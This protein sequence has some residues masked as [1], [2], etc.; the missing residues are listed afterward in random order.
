MGGS[1]D[2]TNRYFG[3]S[4]S[5]EFN[6]KL[7]DML[8]LMNIYNTEDT[9]SIGI[10]SDT[11]TSS[12][13][14]FNPVKK[15]NRL[16]ELKRNDY[17]GDKKRCCLND[18]K[19]YW[20]DDKGN[21]TNPSLSSTLYTC[22]PR[23]HSVG[24]DAYCDD[25]MIEECIDKE[26][27]NKKCQVWIHNLI[28]RQNTFENVINKM[29][30]KCISNVNNMYCKDLLETIR[31]YNYQRFN[32]FADTIL[33]SQ[34]DKTDLKCAFP[35]KYIENEE[36]KTLS[37]KECWYKECVDSELWKL[38]TKNIYK[39]N[40]CQLYECNINIYDLNTVDQSEIKIICKNKD[41]IETQNTVKDVLKSESNYN[42]FLI[43]KFDIFVIFILL[44]IF[45]ITMHNI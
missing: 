2:I 20:L 23:S 33:E 5:Q 30:N 42:M 8:N 39:R 35:P 28:L 43:T 38:L 14:E 12:L 17:I 10:N 24:F 11:I 4:S 26:N 15:P 29:Y 3:H 18:E 21:D 6:L 31:Y 34:K 1:I 45:Y 40:L 44:F 7:G 37:S 32:E 41:I 9:V 13:K 25:V 27:Y 22:N 36:L 16:I 19:F